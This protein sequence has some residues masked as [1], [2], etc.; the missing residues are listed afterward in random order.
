MAEEPLVPDRDRREY[1]LGVLAEMIATGGPAALLAPPVEP[2]PEAFPEPWQP[3]KGG[4]TALLRRLAWH[5]GQERAIAATDERRGAL[6][7]ERKPETHLELT[8]VRKHELALTLSFIGEDDVAGTFAHEIG[9][10][11]AVLSRPDAKDPYRA[12]ELPVLAVDPDRDLERGSIATV[13]LGLGVIAANAAY[14]QY[15]RAEKIIAAYGPLEYD[16][17]RAGYVPMSE[18]AYLLAVQAVVR[19]EAVPPPGLS[20]PQRDE[21]AAWL[22]A[23]HDRKAELRERLGIAPDAQ[24]VAARP[25]AVPFD[26]V[27]V[28]EAAPVQRRAF[29]WQMRRGFFGFAIGLLCAGGAA[30]LLSGAAQAS[31]S[32][33]VYVVGGGIVGHFIGRQ[34]RVTRCSACAT[35]VPLRAERCGKCGA[36]FH[37]DITS[38]SQRLEAE[39][40]LEDG[41]G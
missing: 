35:V 34:I 7:T 28:R 12:A 15:S 6:A 13:Y 32:L 18:L 11:H 31:G 33:L 26:D 5:A 20:G 1:L 2:G 10:A 41:G 21:A 24:G 17:V 4:A 29:R 9:V 30:I 14:Q 39:E 36:T 27:D 23:L 37:G 25:R 22:A 19:G 3:T 40:R 16:V 8:E 38:L